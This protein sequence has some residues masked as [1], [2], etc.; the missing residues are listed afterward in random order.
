MTDTTTFA[1]SINIDV[2]KITDQIISSIE[3]GSGYWMK[4]FNPERGQD[5]ATDDIWYADEKVWA[6][7][8]EIN[9]RI[10]DEKET[11]K[12]T[13]ESVTKGL[14]WLL[15][16]HAWRIEQIVKETGD[17]ET[18]DVFMQACIFQDIVYG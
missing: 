18:A 13:P 7:D 10:H 12:F 14:Q 5:R 6:G 2:K 16:N 11:H 15:A 1:A 4:G 8:F 9:V 3:G 17:A